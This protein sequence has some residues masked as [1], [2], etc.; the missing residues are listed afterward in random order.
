MAVYSTN[1]F[2]AFCKT[3]RRIYR[4]KNING[5]N[6]IASALASCVLMFVLWQGFDARIIIL[7]IACLAVSEAFIQIRWR[8]STLC[9]QCG[10]DPVLYTKSAHAAAAKVKKHL[11]A[12]QQDP[13][14]LFKPPLNLPKISAEK[15]LA[16]QQP[17]KKGQ[18]VSRQI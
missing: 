8:L 2:C 1:A 16:L 15:S 17:E 14:S 10:F 18:L 5:I 9:Q 11:E 6:V 3:P 4:K 12:R 7:F 13:Q